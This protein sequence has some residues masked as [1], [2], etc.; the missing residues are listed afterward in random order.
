MAYQE[1]ICYPWRI[2]EGYKTEVE[3]RTPG[4]KKGK[5]RVKK[6]GGG[7][8]KFRDLP[9]IKARGWNEDVFTRPNGRYAKNAA[10]AIS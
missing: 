2:F 10:I 4:R 3:E 8:E 9:K 5:A 6:D 1:G 7:G